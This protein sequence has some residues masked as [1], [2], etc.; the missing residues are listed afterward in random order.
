MK[1]L[2]LI[3]LLLIMLSGVVYL[4]AEYVEDKER[5]D[6]MLDQQYP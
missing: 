4:R 6:Q 5:T 2:L 3:I 1:K